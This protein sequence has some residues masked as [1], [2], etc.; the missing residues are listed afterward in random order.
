[1]KLKFF[2]RPPRIIAIASDFDKAI[3]LIEVKLPNSN[4]HSYSQAS[5]AS[6]NSN[7]ASYYK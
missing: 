4:P 3:R 6:G 5:G 7:P 1:M 2:L